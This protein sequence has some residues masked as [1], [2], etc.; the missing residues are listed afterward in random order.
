MI[1]ALPKMPG[2]CLD[3]D[4]TEYYIAIKYFVPMDL[5]PNK[6]GAYLYINFEISDPGVDIARILISK[7]A[8]KNGTKYKSVV[9]W[10][11]AL[12]SIDPQSADPGLTYHTKAE[13][14]QNLEF[15]LRRKTLEGLPLKLRRGIYPEEGASN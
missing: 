15:G 1:Y 10:K 4:V 11:D 2:G 14:M 7:K 6:V 5:T 12:W 13:N 3:G 9:F 8:G